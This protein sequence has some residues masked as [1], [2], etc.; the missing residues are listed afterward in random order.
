VTLENEHECS[1]STVAVANPNLRTLIGQTRRKSKTNPPKL[2]SCFRRN[3]KSKDEVSRKSRRLTHQDDAKSI[4]SQR[5]DAK[6]IPIRRTTQS[7]SRIWRIENCAVIGPDKGSVSEIER[8]KETKQRTWTSRL[9]VIS[10]SKPSPHPSIPMPNRSPHNQISTAPKP[11]QRRRTLTYTYRRLSPLLSKPRKSKTYLV[12]A[13][14]SLHMR[15][16]A[17]TPSKSLQQ[18]KFLKNQTRRMRKPYI[19]IFDLKRGQEM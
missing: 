3:R 9:D 16:L 7:Q 2:K 13:L 6:S 8:K 19:A 5:D 4:S 1:F 15:R 10:K 11:Y 12:E 18:P 17:P 14:A